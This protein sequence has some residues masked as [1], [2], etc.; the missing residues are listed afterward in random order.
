MGS[1]SR[2]TI[3]GASLRAA[4]EKAAHVRE[5]PDRLASPAKPDYYIATSETDKRPNPWRWEIRRYSK[6]MGVTFSEDGFRSQSAAEFAGKRA[7]QNFLEQLAAE[8]KRE[9]SRSRKS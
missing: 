5:E 4:E 3:Y 9:Y 6:P 1:K 2:E 8:E 7:L